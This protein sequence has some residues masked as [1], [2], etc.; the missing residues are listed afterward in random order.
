MSF[1]CNSSMNKWRMMVDGW[2]DVG[3]MYYEMMS[4]PEQQETFSTG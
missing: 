2:V 1:A 3:W 4:R